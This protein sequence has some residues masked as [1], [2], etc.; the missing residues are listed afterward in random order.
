MRT[1]FL[2]SHL[3]TIYLSQIVSIVSDRKIE[4]PQESSTR[5]RKGKQEEGRSTGGRE[6]EERVRMIP[7][8]P[9]LPQELRSSS[10]LRGVV[11]VFHFFSMSF[12]KTYIYQICV[13]INK[14]DRS[15]ERGLS[16]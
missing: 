12:G 8:A 3:T 2:T 16:K 15:C 10:A 1:T 6:D 7:S 5:R 4:I 14:H 9:P 11:N 13:F